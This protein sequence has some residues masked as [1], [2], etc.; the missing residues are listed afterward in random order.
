VLFQQRSLID[1]QVS[2]LTAQAEAAAARAAVELA[3]G[4]RSSN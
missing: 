4:Q 1:A 3:V 2:E